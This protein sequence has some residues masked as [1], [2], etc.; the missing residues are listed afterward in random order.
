MA[1]KN[2]EDLFVDELKDIYDA[3]KRL[4]KALPKMARK[5]SNEELSSAFEE[6][7]QQTEDHISRLDSIF[8]SLDKAPGR[9]V[10]DAMVGLLEEGQKKMEE[11][12]PENVMDAGLIGSAQK[13]EHYEIAAYG[14]LRDWANLL[15][16]H[17]AARLL[18]QTLD[19]EGDADKRLTEIAQSLNLEAMEEEEEPVTTGSRRPSRTANRTA[20]RPRHR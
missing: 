20:N 9:K 8:E 1:L 13:V 2:L 10:C 11:E 14:T 6:H 12:G 17:E 15:G 4:T 3:E 16:N 18:Q 5:A 19:E 7:L